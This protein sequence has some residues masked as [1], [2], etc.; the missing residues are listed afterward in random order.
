[1][2]INSDNVKIFFSNNMVSVENDFLAPPSSFTVINVSTTYYLKINL[3]ILIFK[4]QSAKAVFS[5]DFY[6]DA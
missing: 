4:N 1:V 2:L 6:D 3:I 5:A